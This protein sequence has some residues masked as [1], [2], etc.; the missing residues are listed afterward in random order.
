MTVYV[1]E[2]LED[3]E[4]GHIQ[5][6]FAT[7]ELAARWIAKESPHCEDRGEGYWLDRRQRADGIWIFGESYQIHALEVQTE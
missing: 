2:Q 3:H 1:I 6:A 7:E 5:G 4:P